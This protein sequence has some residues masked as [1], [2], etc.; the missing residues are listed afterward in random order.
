MFVARGH[1]VGVSE[2][3]PGR[4]S[5]ARWWGSVGAAMCAATVALGVPAAALAA[6]GPLISGTV[7]NGTSLSGATAVATAGKFAY[8]TAYGSGQLTAV[9]ISN[10]AS[11]VVAG[12]SAPTNSL[13]NASNIAIAGGYAYV[14][15]K[16]R[17]AS[18]TSNDDGTGNS[19]TILDIH[20]NPAQPLIVGTVTDAS[21]LFGAYGIAVSGSFAYVAAQGC[22]TLQPCPNQAAGNSF[23]AIDVSN[24]AAPK[25]LVTLHNDSLP[26]PWT[27]TNALEHISSVAVSGTFAYVTAGYSSRITVIDISDPASPVIVGSLHDATNLEFPVDVTVQGGFAYVANQGGNPADPQLAIVDISNPANPTIAGTLDNS[28][29]G[30]AYRVAVNG[31]FAYIAASAASAAAIVDVSNP[32]APTLDAAVFSPV[33]LTHTTGLALAPGG[34]S[35]IMASPV[36]HGES[37]ALFPPF[38]NQSGGPTETGTVSAIALDPQPTA[39]SISASSEP[40]TTTVTTSADFHFQTSNDVGTTRCKL[41]GGTFALCTTPASQQYSGLGTGAHTF[42]VEVIEASGATATAS[43]GWNVSNGTGGAPANTAVPAISGVLIRGHALAATAGTWSGTPAPAFSYK[44]SRCT[45]A[46]AR[47]TAIAGATSSTYTLARA[48][49]NSTIDVAVTATNGAGTATA[50]SAHTAV[51]LPSG[52]RITK[53]TIVRSRGR[54]VLHV[55]LTSAGS[56]KVTVRRANAKGGPP[57]ELVSRRLPAGS[58]RLTLKFQARRGVTYRV[59]AKAQNSKH[60]RF[61]AGRR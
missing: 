9:D 3:P 41:D 20:T 34:Q 31:P 44:W 2:L 8:T 49:V 29:L 45:A 48:D 26:A 40:P 59:V 15:S 54:Y 13:L 57:V 22:L 1:A 14:V 53:L 46:G 28:F 39:I 11:P 47:C 51:V 30:G 25:Q 10:P 5:R 52:G 61:T 50:T 56:V 23:T 19:L 27:G 36:Q 21:N 24:P 38:P 35:L 32:A 42:T 33:D 12:S 37:F 60:L 16:N 17:N 6:G 4:V 18:K 43:Y 55:A 7:A 58:S